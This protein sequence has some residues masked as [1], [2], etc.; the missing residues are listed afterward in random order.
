MGGGWLSQAASDGV[1]VWTSVFTGH[2]RIEAHT[3]PRDSRAAF[4]KQ[5]T[6]Q[7]DVRRSV[8]VL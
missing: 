3:R 4:A 8:G 5:G 6:F 7:L 1:C 2:P